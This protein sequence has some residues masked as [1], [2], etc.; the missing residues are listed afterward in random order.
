MKSRN[1]CIYMR[2]VVTIMGDCF[3]CVKMNELK[4]LRA[5]N[6][7]LK[8]GREIANLSSALEKEK[9]K[10]AT[11]QGR[12]RKL[13][14]E[15]NDLK[16]ETFHIRCDYYADSHEIEDLKE[17]NS[18]LRTRIAHYDESFNDELIEAIEGIKCKR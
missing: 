8:S 2:I 7:R 5:E 12:N 16:T 9:R 3:Y 18:K 11:L 15:I 4:S 1:M 13:H 6:D 17:E 10:N 14:Q